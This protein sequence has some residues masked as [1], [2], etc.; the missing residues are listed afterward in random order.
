MLIKSVCLKSEVEECGT[1]TKGMMTYMRNGMDWE[2]KYV[3]KH[4]CRLSNCT[5]TVYAGMGCFGV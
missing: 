3:C 1:E 4:F 5:E 2:I